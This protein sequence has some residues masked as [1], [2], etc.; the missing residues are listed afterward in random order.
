MNNM[1]EYMTGGQCYK[2]GGKVRY[3]DGG[4]TMQQDQA[5][6][7]DM[8]QMQKQPMRPPSALDASA[9][10]LM[11]FLLQ[12]LDKG[13]SERILKKTLIDSGV[14]R[15]QAEE[16]IM[17]A[18]QEYMKRAQEGDYVNEKAREQQLQQEQ[19]MALQQQMG[20]FNN[21]DPMGMGQQAGPQTGMDQS[22]MA[23]AQGTDQQQMADQEMAMQ[24]KYGG[25]MKKLRRYGAGGNSCPDGYEWNEMT[26]TCMPTA[27]TANTASQ[28]AGGMKI[29]GG[30]EL[31]GPQ[32]A[33]AGMDQYNQNVVAS[34]QAADARNSAQANFYGNMLSTYDANRVAQKEASQQAIG[35]LYSGIRNDQMTN[36]QN[37]F[38]QS[39]Q[40]ATN[41]QPV[42]TQPTATQ[43]YAR[44]G[45]LNKFVNGGM[46]QYGAGGTEDGCPIGYYKGPDG[47]CLKIFGSDQAQQEY[48]TQVVDFYNSG[49]VDP[50]M[51]RAPMQ[52]YEEFISQ[53]P[54]QD[55]MYTEMKTSPAAYQNYVNQ[56]SAT[57][58][59]NTGAT[60]QLSYDQ[61]KT[62]AANNPSGAMPTDPRL[63][64]SPYIVMSDKNKIAN[65]D[66]NWATRAM[67]VSNSFADPRFAPIT[68]GFGPGLKFL[69]GAAAV[70]G[71]AGLGIAKGMAGDESRVYDDK[72]N[73][74]FYNSKRDE[75]RALNKNQPASAPTQ[76]QGYVQPTTSTA[77][78]AAPPT[79][80]TGQDKVNY[81]NSQ[82]N[83][84]K[85]PEGSASGDLQSTDPT[86]PNYNPNAGSGTA[87]PQ[88]V[89]AQ[90]VAQ[91][92]IMTNLSGPINDEEN[93]RDGGEWNPFVDNRRKL[94]IT[95]PMYAPGGAVDTETSPYSQQDWASKTGRPFPLNRNDW[96]AYNTYVSNFNNP[97]VAGT[98]ST[99][100]M[101]NTTDN[102]NNA[103]SANPNA[104]MTDTKEY[105]T[106]QGDP[107]GF[108][109]ASNTYQGLTMMED[110]TAQWGERRA[111]KD[112]K[113]RQKQA[114]NTMMANNAIN[115]Q[116]SFGTWNLNAGPGANQYV[117]DL[118]HTQDWGTTL[119]KFGG[120]KNYRRGGTYM[121]SP[122]ELQ[123]IIQMGGEVEFLD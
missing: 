87:S 15:D 97:S 106:Q 116:G 80:V 52:S 2:C 29:F 64:N 70:A 10:Q 32:G 95:M 23:M 49:K 84:N 98:P 62:G 30:N 51:N 46:K 57:N 17:V 9:K 105:T 101:I 71:G 90:P 56:Y 92:S 123:A 121:I 12:Q 26:A 22:Q 77:P 40:N 122:Q 93:K 63:T 24:G 33:K 72:G 94:R 3:A 68:G 117:A 11:T 111:V 8:G 88:P 104:N 20:M 16:L 28:G 50:S 100:G 67:A 86:A 7:A 45:G 14:K 55:Q 82:L 74:F 35:N 120:T 61:W 38:F 37:N 102:T 54:A 85:Q 43:G 18:K 83:V 1:L 76:N 81:M 42:V 110:A 103:L 115:T 118:G 89:T 65:I 34:A 114:G 107:L 113:K 108:K 36:P 73:V 59:S 69:M 109:A 66:S 96:D 39:F 91:P 41:P 31:T 47:D 112:L 19:Q 4:D 21:Q 75:K 13:T 44:Y 25:S 99:N 58:A 60:P 53:N 119:S 48:Q 5:A 79:T 6:V 78:E 27:V